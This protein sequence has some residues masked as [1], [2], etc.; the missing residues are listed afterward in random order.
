M[1]E[2]HE[3]LQH[4]SKDSKTLDDKVLWQKIQS[5]MK[6][7]TTMLSYSTWIEPL[8]LDHLDKDRAIVYLSWPKQ[9]KLINH[10]KDHYN[11]QLEAAFCRIL[12]KD[13]RVVINPA[14]KSEM[15]ELEPN[16]EESSLIPALLYL[17]KEYTFDHFFYND[18]L[19]AKIA[20]YAAKA[21]AEHLIRDFNPLVICGGF[22]SGKTHLLQAIGN[23]IIKANKTAK[24]LIL[25]ADYFISQYEDARERN[26]Q[27]SFRNEITSAD[28]LLVDDIQF[29]R[30]IRYQ[31][32]FIYVFDSYYCQNKPIVL[33][34]DEHPE[35]SFLMSNSLKERLGWGLVTTLEMPDHETRKQILKDTIERL[36]IEKNDDVMAVVDYIAHKSYL[37]P[38]D[39]KASMKKV[40]AVSKIFGNDVN[41]ENA[42]MILRGV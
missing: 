31:R 29:L 9:E 32:A 24:V 2:Y 10:I 38:R 20:P 1:K 5:E 35:A 17:N 12:K 30:D 36:G 42:E 23:E 40:L 6:T 37:T 14:G 18:S 25:S 3:E 7:N 4:Q 13:Y 8:K 15:D 27:D 21:V 41:V 33:T 19:S 16:R 39:V 26:L 22:G 11:Q 28:C 34:S